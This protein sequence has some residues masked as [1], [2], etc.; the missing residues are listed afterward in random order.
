MSRPRTVIRL[1]R[2]AI[3]SIDASADLNDRK[4]SGEFEI[5]VH[6]A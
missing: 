4:R 3:S 1:D 6:S 5:G 2:A